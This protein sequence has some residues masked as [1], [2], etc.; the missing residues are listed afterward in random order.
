MISNQS[1]NFSLLE[2]KKLRANQT[3]EKQREIN[4]TYYRQ[5]EKVCR[6]AIEKINKIKVKFID[7][8]EET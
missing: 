7:S 5:N 4:C 2:I 6:K 3:Q 8:F 1:P